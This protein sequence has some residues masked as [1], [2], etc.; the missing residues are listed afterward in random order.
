MLILIPTNALI[1]HLLPNTI[2]RSAERAFGH[3]PNQ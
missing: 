2:L 1:L 3:G